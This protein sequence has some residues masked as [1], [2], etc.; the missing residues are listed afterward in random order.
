MVNSPVSCC[1]ELVVFECNPKHAHIGCRHKKYISKEWML[2]HCLRL[3]SCCSIKTEL[4]KE[5]LR[6]EK[7]ERLEAVELS[8]KV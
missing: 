8:R 7:K 2:A 6:K 5:Q 3:T 4:R 1:T